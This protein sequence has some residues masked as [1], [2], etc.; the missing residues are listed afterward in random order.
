MRT[1]VYGS[2]RR[3]GRRYLT[4]AVAV[5]V[6]VG[7]LVAVNAL[8]SSAKTGLS[9]GIALPFADADV[10]ASELTGDEAQAL[11]ARAEQE[12]AQAAV[13]GWT[14]QPVRAG[15]RLLGSDLDLGVI[16]PDQRFRWQELRSGRYPERAGEAVIDVNEAKRHR[17]EPGELLTVGT[18]PTTVRVRV[19]GV[20]D[21]P[22]IF[23]AAA[24]YL[25]WDDLAPWA[26]QL[27]VDSVLW[28]QGT[29]PEAQLEQLTDWQPTATV[30]LRDDHVEALKVEIDRGVDILALIGLLFVAIAVC[31]AVLVI[32]N[33][34][35]IIF[36]QRAR[37]LAL[38]RCV[39]ATRG[40]LLR[41][42]R[43]EALAI[44][45]TASLLGVGLGI[46]GGYGLVA[47][48]DAL[49]DSFTMGAIAWNPL[50][51]GAAAL[52][53]TLTTVVA[54]WLPT[55]RVV[56]VRPLQAL[57]PEAAQPITARAGALRL[58]CGVGLLLLGS[59]ALAWA[60]REHQVEPMLAGGITV[61]AGVLALGPLLV[62]AVIRAIGR[63]LAPLGG[64]PARLATRNAV[65]N[66]R[67]SASTTAALLIGVT[68]TS[69]VL[70]GLAT[71]RGAVAEEMDRS[72]PVDVAITAGRA[73][74][75][76]NELIAAI[77]R[78][79]DV[80]DVDALRGTTVRSPELGRIDVAVAGSQAPRS[81]EPVSADDDTVLMPIDLIGEAG[82]PERVR[83]RTAQG[84]VL[85]RTEVGDGWGNIALVSATTLA[86]LS[87]EP[88]I[89]AA[90]VRA[91]DG[92]DA[93]D[94]TGDLT[95]L[96][97]SEDAAVASA[98]S[99]RGYVDLQLTVL[100]AAIVGLLGISVL[101]ALVGIAGTLG[102]SVLERTRE[103][104]MLR[105]VG[106]SRGGLR[107]LLGFEAALLSVT[108]TVIGVA[109]GLAF[110]WVAIRTVVTP[111][112][113]GVTMTWPV[114]Q[115]VAVVAISAVAGL[116]SCVLP[117][118]RAV[119]IT[120]I[121]GLAQE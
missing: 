46:A 53:G 4:A 40:Q 81:S 64:A 76:S 59:V 92:A 23:V 52:L 61:F 60:V 50:W 87:A 51:I 10:V 13:L 17:L 42:V 9:S 18:A 75:L 102:L 27:S 74:P 84:S 41:S 7:F 2:L 69:A 82:L 48:I 106:L 113:P 68:L 15:Q 26:D 99:Q 93:E 63:L 78:Q 57:R 8:T 95:A 90:W 45:A 105:A 65:R 109:L 3:Y 86:R 14:P 104:A 116:A 21:T 30:E 37:D 16:A 35:A 112:V 100:T 1:V 88:T 22:S 98:L 20:V 55:R 121:A 80:L 32:A 31:V 24:V 29:S 108:A 77:G 39:G 38:L 73:E 62:P 107:R 85:L 66:P 115:L 79:R 5:M 70:T 19:V 103:H 91:R 111:A 47:A 114:G 34:F 33:T 28:S 56:R 101:I 83:L 71:A 54:A 25:L 119:R 97:A 110:A 58:G 94:L 96:A 89:R 44:G 67:R 117:A 11:M 49:S 36:A 72:D 118:R 43:L 12:H 6:A 120:P